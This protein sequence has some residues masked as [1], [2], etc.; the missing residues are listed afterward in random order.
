[1]C[2]PL[3]HILVFLKTVMYNK[4]SL[5]IKNTDSISCTY[6]QSQDTALMF[7]QL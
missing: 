1:M 7:S 4:T 6:V 5:K 3:G 2:F